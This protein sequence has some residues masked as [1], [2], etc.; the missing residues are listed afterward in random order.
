MSHDPDG[1]LLLEPD[2]PP[3]VTV[4]DAD[5]RSPFVVTCDHASNRV[6]RRLAGLGLSEAER[7]RHIAWDIGAL[8][9]ARRLAARLGAPLVAAGYSRLVIDLNRPL[10][11]R[12]LMAE[13]SDATPVPGNHG[14]SPA[15]RQARIDQLFRPYHAAISA[16][17]DR[18][19]AAGRPSLLV[20]QHS[21]TPRLSG[22]AARPW[23]I[24]LAPGRDRR[25][26]EL[27]AA[28]L[29]RDPALVVG[30]DEPYAIGPASDYGVPVHGDGRGIPAVLIEIRQDGVA[31]DAGAARWADRLAGSLAAIAPA[32][33]GDTP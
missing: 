15:D 26:G 24:G 30:W 13:I 11:A 31:G 27:L 12:D 23:H 4:T 22:G 1:P 9:V 6:P 18:R 32:L 14:L 21:F 29:R 17:L 19:A 33:L 25:F 16:L 28:A 7:D 3:A 10:A 5:G 2:E 8:A 20:C